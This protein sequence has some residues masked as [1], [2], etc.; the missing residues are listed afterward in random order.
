MGV[1][2]MRKAQEKDIKDVFFQLDAL[3][4][5]TKST[6]KNGNFHGA[7]NPRV[8][9]LFEEKAKSEEIKIEAARK[10]MKIGFD[11]RVKQKRTKSPQF[12]LGSIAH[13]RRLRSACSRESRWMAGLAL[14][15][16]S[17]QSQLVS[18]AISAAKIIY[19]LFNAI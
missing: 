6:D 18:P 10:A 14:E 5:I 2:N 1:R 3:G 11:L 19:R 8:H 9:E 15:N 4:W 12:R 17:T 13:R 16:S 7:V